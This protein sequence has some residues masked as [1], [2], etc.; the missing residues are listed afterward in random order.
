[1]PLTTICTSGAHH[2][3]AVPFLAKYNGQGSDQRCHSPAE[4]LRTLDTQN[5]F[6]IVAPYLLACNHGGADDRSA[7]LTEPMRTLTTKTGHSLVIPFLAKYYG[8]GG[9]RTVDEPLDTVTA[10]DRF[11]LA[12]ASLLGTMA[13]LH[14][15]DIGF[16]MLQPHELLAAQGFPTGYQ[17]HGNKAE[18]VKQIGNAVCPPVAE[19]LCRTMAEAA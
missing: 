6:G 8:T 11:G 5:R 17:L 10:R 15:A 3:L 16:R 14:V 12:M 13:E 2:G 4:P 9:S 19:A 18:Q 1:M 7:S